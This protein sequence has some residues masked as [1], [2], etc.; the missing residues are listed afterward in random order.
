MIGNKI[1]QITEVE[2]AFQSL[3]DLPDGFEKPADRTKAMGEQVRQFL[4]QRMFCLSR[5]W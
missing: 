3:E 1:E 5:L 2:Y 4:R